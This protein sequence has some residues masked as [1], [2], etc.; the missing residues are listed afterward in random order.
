MKIAF[1]G[2]GIMGY[3]MARNLLKQ[4]ADVTVY[5]RTTEKA[6]ELAAHGANVASTAL[7]AIQG[8]EV[9]FTMLSRPEVVQEVA[10]GNGG[11]LT[12]MDAGSIWIDCSTVNPSFT[13]ASAQQAEKH[14]IKFLGAPVAGTKPHA[15]N[16]E[17]VFFVGGATETLEIVQPLMEMMGKKVLHIGESVEQGASFKMLVNSLLAQSMAVFSETFLLGEKMG[18]SREFLL[19]ALPG[20]VVTAP[21][22]QAKVGMIESDL[23][24]VQFPLELMHKDLKLVSKTAEEVGQPLFTAEVVKELYGNAVKGGLGREDFAAIHRHMAT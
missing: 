11:F 14:G 5:N 16:A 7:E 9:V 23:Y 4:G 17:L 2:L 20:L 18:L 1:I 10:W 12:G 13:K 6:Q 22:I 8:A 21:F 3:R 15:E 19:K 24:D